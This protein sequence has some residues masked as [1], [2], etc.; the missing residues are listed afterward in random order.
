MVAPRPSFSGFAWGHLSAQ[1]NSP[2]VA[3]SAHRARHGDR[4]Q[5][6]CA[7]PRRPNAASSDKGSRIRALE[8][9]CMSGHEEDLWQDP[10]RRDWPLIPSLL[11]GSRWPD[12]ASGDK[13][14]FFRS[15]SVSV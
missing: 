6:F 10:L 7:D 2:E 15:S 11:R 4:F 3:L 8:R 12:A 5:V 14:S 9:E 1:N 13:G